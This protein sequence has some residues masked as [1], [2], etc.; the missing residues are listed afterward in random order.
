MLS[1]RVLEKKTTIRHAYFASSET[2]RLPTLKK[3]VASR[4]AFPLL[5]LLSREK[6]LRLGFTPIDD[7]RVIVALRNVRGRV[8]DIGCGSNLFVRSYGNGVGVDVYPW[9]GCDEVVP[10][11][12]HLPFKS[13][14]FNTVSF[15]ACLN[16]IPNRLQT[17]QE[18]VRVLKPDGQVL[19]TMIPPKLG[20]FIHWLRFHNDPDH[21]ERD[22]D[23]AHEMLGMSH[24]QVQAFLDEAGFII[25][26]QKS[27]VFGLNSL[28]IA[29]LSN[30]ARQG[31]P[32]SN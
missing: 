13:G 8:L 22:I 4:I 7:E 6:S 2:I 5:C 11:T 27:F 12:A 24:R 29:E 18:A 28:Y 20:K 16:H 10:N 30:E 14:T 21:Q 9:E 25:K 26:R 23:H 32:E 3:I 1:Q 17:L 15:L 19:I 31:F